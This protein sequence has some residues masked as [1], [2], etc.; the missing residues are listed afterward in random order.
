M[1]TI[2]RGRR[3]DLSACQTILFPDTSD[4]ERRKAEV[5]HWRR[6]ARDPALDFYVAQQGGGL[7]GMLLV[8]YIR[9]LR[10]AGWLAVV[11]IALLPAAP[12]QVGPALLDFAKERARKRACPGLVWLPDSGQSSAQLAPAFLRDNGFQQV[13]AFWSCPLA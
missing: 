9:R 1:L 10:Q 3:T 7:Q 4:D 5:R 13:G 11:D 2:R 8:S 6:L 12:A